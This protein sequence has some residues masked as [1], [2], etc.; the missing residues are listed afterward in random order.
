M[1]FQL[2]TLL[3]LRRNAE[4][5]AQQ[6]LD[7]A[8][9]VA[10]TEE[11]EQARRIGRWQEACTTMTRENE[12]LAAS[13]SPTTAAQAAARA[14]YLLRLRDETA[15]LASLAKEHRATALEAAKAAEGAAQAAYEEARKAREA[16]EKLRERAQAEEQRKAERRADESASDLAQAT[17]FKRRLE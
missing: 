5:G 13:P 8:M 16:V 17:H 11:E 15:R 12:R 2:Q 9:A 7:L 6:A 3:D 14:Q 10:H 1:T 4:K